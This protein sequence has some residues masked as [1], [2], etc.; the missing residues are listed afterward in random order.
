PRGRSP[1][2]TATTDIGAGI[3]SFLLFEIERF[4]EAGVAL[5][6]GRHPHLE[7]LEFQHPSMLGVL[8]FHGEEALLEALELLRGSPRCR[9]EYAWVGARRG[10]EHLTLRGVDAAGRLLQHPD[11]VAHRARVGPAVVERLE[12]L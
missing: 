3:T 7:P 11:E 10:R 8:P 2:S 4:V 5:L 6:A 12:H 1:P 9:V